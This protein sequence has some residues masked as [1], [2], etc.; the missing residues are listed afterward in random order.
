MLLFSIAGEMTGFLLAAAVG[1]GVAFQAA[2]VFML[3]P[4]E[5]SSPLN[6]LLNV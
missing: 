3:V 1:V 2:C 4:S 6:A 5:A